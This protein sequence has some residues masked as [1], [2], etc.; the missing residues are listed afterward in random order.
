MA[1]LSELSDGQLEKAYIRYAQAHKKAPSPKTAKVIQAIQVERKKRQ[2]AVK[3]EGEPI[4]DLAALSRS[5]DASVKKKRQKQQK[6]HSKAQKIPRKG[7]GPAMGQLKGNL[8]LGAGLIS[9]LSGLVLLADDFL[10]SYLSDF[11][12][13]M[14][15]YS[16]L[17][18]FGVLA[19]KLS[20]MLMD[21]NR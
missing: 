8:L 14:F 7:Q 2:G 10:F 21:D 5:A 17:I 1:K 4:S 6:V 13:K 9:G 16:V 12:Y 19:S 15:L 3:T 11:P 20:S 18:F